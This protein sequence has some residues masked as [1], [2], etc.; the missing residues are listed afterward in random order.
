MS[1]LKASSDVFH[2]TVSKHTLKALSEHTLKLNKHRTLSDIQTETRYSIDLTHKRRCRSSE[3]HTS[4][5]EATELNILNVS[6]LDD[7]FKST[8]LKLKLL[9][10]IMISEDHV[11]LKTGVMMLKIQL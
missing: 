3:C 11:T 7:K 10:I 6:F 1:I 4:L 9:C 8:S 5:T 2:I